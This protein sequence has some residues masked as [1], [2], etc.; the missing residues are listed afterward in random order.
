VQQPRAP[1]GAGRG[2]FG[3]VVALTLLVLA[4]LLFADR[5]GRLAA[6]VGLTTIAAAVV[7]LGAAIAVAGIRGRS[8]GGLG[9]L[10]IVLMLVA[11]PL[12]AADRY[13][14][15]STSDGQ[16]V[17]GDI[18]STPLTASDAEAGI[19]LGA[20]NATIDLTSLPAST[21]TVVVPIDVAAGDV[22][23]VVPSGSTVSADLTMAAG[24]VRWFGDRM[25]IG[26]GDES[27]KS[28]EHSGTGDSTGPD[29]VLDISMGVGSLTVQ[30]A[31]R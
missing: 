14:W 1:R 20:G 6:P 18:S 3:V 28:L 19:E 29:L 10:A 7:F 22:T 13:D 30:E 16:V 17:F 2:T 15:T 5:L 8:A 21:A 24:D 25:S 27:P 26:F 11:A 31:G 23:V 9:A 12:A 4:G